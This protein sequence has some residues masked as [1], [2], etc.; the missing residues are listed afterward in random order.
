MDITLILLKQ[1]KIEKL[2]RTSSHLMANRSETNFED[3]NEM[4]YIWP[5]ILIKVCRSQ[6]TVV[7]VCRT[8]CTSKGSNAVTGVDFYF[9]INR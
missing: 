2:V 6:E 7:L 8:T 5:G 1:F 9:A 4:F 3:E